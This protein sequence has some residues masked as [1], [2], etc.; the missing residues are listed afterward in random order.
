M[1][2]MSDFCNH[3]SSPVGTTLISINQ[4]TEMLKRKVD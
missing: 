4:I 1:D 2:I 3:E